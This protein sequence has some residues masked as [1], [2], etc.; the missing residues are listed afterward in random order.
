VWPSI[1]LAAIDAMVRHRVRGGA[2]AREIVSATAFVVVI[3]LSFAAVRGT[4]RDWLSLPIAT[5]GEL[6]LAI[7]AF[8]PIGVISVHGHAQVIAP[9]L[10]AILLGAY[11]EEVVFRVL[12]PVFL[13]CA[14]EAIGVINR[15]RRSCGAVAAQ[16]ALAI[17]AIGVRSCMVQTMIAP[18]KRMKEQPPAKLTVG[19]F[20]SDVAGC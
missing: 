11:V 16:V 20:V 1:R 9:L 2:P 6:P 10:A 12:L 19:L 14:F 18:T 3:T 13:T 8:L 5:V 7:L 15:W 17:G 4:T